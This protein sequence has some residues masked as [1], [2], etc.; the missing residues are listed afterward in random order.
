MPALGLN[1][2]MDSHNSAGLRP[3]GSDPTYYKVT[4]AVLDVWFG[5][6]F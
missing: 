2:L 3:L 5:R 1:G 4:L 6:L